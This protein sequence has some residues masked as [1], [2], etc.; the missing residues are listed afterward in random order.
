MPALVLASCAAGAAIHPI[1][2][3]ERPAI[4]NAVASSLPTRP[5][6]SATNALPTAKPALVQQRH[7]PLVTTTCTW[8]ALY[9]QPSALRGSFRTAKATPTG[10]AFV[11]RTAKPAGVPRN[12]SAV[13]RAWCCTR[14]NASQS[15]CPLGTLIRLE[16]ANAVNLHAP[17]A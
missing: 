4:Q 15:V 7:V 13:A 1:S 11:Q 16:C 5:P 9:V 14:E 3:T 12:A 10:V 8:M 2:W 17:H 6:E